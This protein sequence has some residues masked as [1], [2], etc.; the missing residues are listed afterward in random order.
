MSLLG[1]AMRPRALKGID[2]EAQ[3]SLPGAVY[4]PL[5][6]RSTWT[7]DWLPA[8]AK[9]LSIA[10]F[11]GAVRVLAETFAMIPLMVY[12]RLPGGGKERATDHPRGW[13]GR[14]PV[15]E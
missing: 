6:N 12:R 11:Y 7:M 8:E 9:A 14:E 15:T 3:A 10:T 2:Q 5:E 4:V 13:R 1:L